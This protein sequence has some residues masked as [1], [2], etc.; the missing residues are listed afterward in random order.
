MP[1]LG[2]I[3]PGGAFSAV[4]GGRTPIWP[5]V[6][7]I[8]GMAVTEFVTDLGYRQRYG[9]SGRVLLLRF[10]LRSVRRSEAGSRGLWCL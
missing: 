8:A 6:I 3:P 2:E 10:F 9:E 7:R 1:P 5:F 4:C